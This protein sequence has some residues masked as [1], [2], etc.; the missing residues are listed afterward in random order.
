MVLPLG[1]H[2]FAARVVVDRVQHGVAFAC[3]GAEVHGGLPAVRADLE[4]G[5]EPRGLEAGLVQREALVR[6]HEPLGRLG[7]RPQVRVQ[8]G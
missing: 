4:Q 1:L 2:L 8:R 5:A 6:R 7:D 3:R